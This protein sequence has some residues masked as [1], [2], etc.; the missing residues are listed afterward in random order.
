MRLRR[1]EA[2]FAERLDA[3]ETVLQET[4]RELALANEQI[5]QLPG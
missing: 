2:A 5:R 4:L 3:K 1:A